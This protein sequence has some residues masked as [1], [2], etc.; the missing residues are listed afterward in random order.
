M[1]LMNKLKPLIGCLSAVLL[2]GVLMALNQTHLTPADASYYHQRVRDAVDDIP[3]QIGPWHGKD[4]EIPLAAVELLRPNVMFSRTYLHQ[5]TGK[6]FTLL[7]VHC[8]DARDLLG[9]Y[10]PVCYPGQGWRINSVENDLVLGEAGL[11]GSQ[12][13]LAKHKPWAL[14]KMEHETSGPFS[15][16]QSVYQTMLLPD[17]TRTTDMQVVQRFAGDH[18]VRH[19]GAAQVQIVT[20]PGS[21]LDPEELQLILSALS[22]VDQAISDF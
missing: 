7:I 9:H 2:L 12:S 22:N 16:E 19:F 10:P 15:G 3:Y 4:Q 14:Y 18:E 6:S 8:K 21:E 20:G 5:G 1:E 11:Q 13:D 17:G